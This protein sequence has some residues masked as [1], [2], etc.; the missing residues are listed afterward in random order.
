MYRMKQAGA[1][2]I[3][4]DHPELALSLPELSGT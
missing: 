1:D 2:G 3:I 4:T